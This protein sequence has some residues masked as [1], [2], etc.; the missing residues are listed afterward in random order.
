[1]VRTPQGPRSGIEEVMRL[2]DIHKRIREIR[3]LAA[4]F[5][6]EQAH[7]EEDQLLEDVLRA[8]STGDVADATARGASDLARAALKVK[9]IKYTRYMG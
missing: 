9:R 1:M 8:I 2:A 6:N 7:S 3:K 4:N 5:D